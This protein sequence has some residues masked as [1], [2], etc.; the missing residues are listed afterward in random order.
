MALFLE[1]WPDADSAEGKEFFTNA[2]TLAK[3]LTALSWPRSAMLGALARAEMESSLRTA[4]TGDDGEAHGLWQWHADRIKA[5]KDGCG[6]DINKGPDIAT[7]CKALDWELTTYAYFGRK[8]IFSCGT[9]NAAGIVFC[10]LVDRAGAPNAALRTGMAAVRWDKSGLI[11][12]Q[13]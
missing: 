6:I 5:I 4:V 2:Q 12:I 10:T 9:P 11:A 1:P 3:A 7:Q 13:M 8:D